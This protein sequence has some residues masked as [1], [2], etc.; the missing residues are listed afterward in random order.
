[1]GLKERLKKLEKQLKISNPVEYILFV[2][3]QTGESF[4]IETTEKE[5][6]QMW[7]DNLHGRPNKLEQKF[8]DAFER[9]FIDEGGLVHLLRAFNEKYTNIKDLWEDEYYEKQSSSQT[10]N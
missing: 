10:V 6:E 3:P 2:N 8:H 9:G 5:I 4:Y 1:M 7:D